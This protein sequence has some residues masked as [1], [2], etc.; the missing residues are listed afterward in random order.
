MTGKCESGVALA[1]HVMLRLRQSNSDCSNAWLG[2]QSS[3]R[4]K[5]SSS[6]LLNF[7]WGQMGLK[8]TAA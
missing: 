3:V 7:G 5:S 8:R 1:G 6:T 4:L 2:M